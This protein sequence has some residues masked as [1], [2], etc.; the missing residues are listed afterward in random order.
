MNTNRSRSGAVTALLALAALL[1]G[2]AWAAERK[3]AGSFLRQ[4]EAW[5]AGGEAR[6][7]ADIILTFQSDA[8]GWPK[9]IDT[10]SKPFEGARSELAPTFDNGATCDELRFL[11]RVFTAT[12]DGKYRAAFDRGLAY[13]LNA[14]YANGGWPQ[15]YPARGYSRDVTFNDEAMVRLMRFVRDAVGQP[16]FAFLDEAQ[17]KAC[18]AA[19]DKGIGC[20]LKCQIRVEGRPTVWCAQHDPE[21]L[22][23]SRARAF[24]LAS[25][26]GGESVGVTR[27]L[28]SLEKPSPA[29]KAAVEGAV[30]WFERAKLAGI[31]LEQRDD[32]LGRDGKNRVVVDEPHAPPLWARFYDLKTGRP[33]F[34]DRDG[35]PKATLAEI[36]YERRNGY[37]WYGTWPLDLLEKDYPAWKQRVE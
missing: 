13:V 34:C 33:F 17:R 31:R 3:S 22:A 2:D 12:R 26:S 25:F 35:V 27:L 18:Q 21:T 10:V 15:S 16:G 9:N 29:V 11:A 14:Q 32:P 19:F 1:A 36:G 23:P 30:A 5:F 4:P 28:M 37:D 8:G 6:T 7:A 20:I 24:E